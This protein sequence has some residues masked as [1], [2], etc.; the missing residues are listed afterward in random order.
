MHIT[1]IIL[2]LLLLFEIGV[3]YSIKSTNMMK[4]A[5]IRLNINSNFKLYQTNLCS[6]SME[7]MHIILFNLK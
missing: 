6:F 1:I 7:H 2:L 3:S 5:S 4:M